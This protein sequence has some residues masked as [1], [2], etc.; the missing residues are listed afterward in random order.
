MDIIDT[1]LEKR[2]Q[3]MKELLKQIEEKEKEDG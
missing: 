1:H 2:E 3:L